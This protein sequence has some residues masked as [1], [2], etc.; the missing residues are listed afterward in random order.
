MFAH[1]TLIH[2]F[3][4]LFGTCAATATYVTGIVTIST[5]HGGL[6]DPKVVQIGDRLKVKRA[7]SDFETRTVDMLSGTGLDITMISVKD[8]Y[9]DTPTALLHLDTYAWVD[10]SGTTESLECGRRGNCK[11]GSGSVP[12]R[13]ATWGWTAA[14][15]RCDQRF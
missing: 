6:I 13:R 12:A 2:V 7:T 11:R 10:D 9:L 4:S 3:R 8:K 15:T 1:L 5:Y 14:S